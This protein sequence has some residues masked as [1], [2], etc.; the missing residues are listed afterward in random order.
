MKHDKIQIN[1]K[2][3]RIEFNW[4][5]LANFL[6]AEN[7]KLSEIDKLEE[8]SAKMVTALI[9]EGVKEGARMQ[10]DEFNFTKED[11]G[12]NI[13]TTDVAAMLMIYRRQSEVKTTVADNHSPKKKLTIFKR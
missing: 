5:A 3:Y 9:Y 4:N 11:F 10:G 12:A 6:E 1:D 7:L 8:L 2:Q 13:S